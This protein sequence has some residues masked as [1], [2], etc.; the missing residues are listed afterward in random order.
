MIFWKK[1]RISRVLRSERDIQ[2]LLVEC[3]GVPCRAWN[4]P[5]LTGEARVGDEVYL[6]TTAV[7]LGLGSGGYH[8]VIAN[9]NRLPHFPEEPGHIMKL[10]Y[11]P[12]QLKV[13]SVEEEAS[14]HHGRIR[15]FS[16]LNGTPVIVG[17]LHSMLA[18][19]VAGCLSEA[20]KGIRIAYVMTD[21]AA[22]P[23]ALSSTVRILK[24]KGMLA[25]TVTA[26]H[27]FGGDLESVN[28]YSGLIA[29]YTVFQADVIVVTMGPGIVG[30]GTNWGTTALEQGEI[31]NAVSVLGGQPVVIPRISFADPRPR[32]RGVSHHTL[33]ALG[34]VA[35]RQAVV[36]LPE[37]PAP[38]YELVEEQLALEGILSR[39]R[40]ITVDG[41]P[42][43]KLLEQ[44]GITVRSMGRTP[45]ED[46]AFFLAAGAAGRFAAGNL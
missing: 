34:K 27:A 1:G 18:P 35:L 45:A 46:P 41:S 44:E 42:A 13:L 3:E 8:F 23:L 30:T 33:T 36:V 21:G 37:M 10:R 29:A 25:G 6:N 12:C 16:S 32:H 17:T 15:D 39:H 20:K 24:R 9:L 31:V 38:Q 28:I 43:L 26:G 14:P 19:A 22:L 40:V 4:Y 5:L 2:E 11:T 7:Q